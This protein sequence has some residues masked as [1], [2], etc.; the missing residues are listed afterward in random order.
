[1]DGRLKAAFDSVSTEATYRWHTRRLLAQLPP[2]YV[3]IQTVLG[4][5]ADVRL[6]AWEEMFL[7]VKLMSWIRDLEVP[8][9]EG[10]MGPLVLDERLLFDSQT[11]SLER[12]RPPATFRWFLGLGLLWGI[13]LTLLTLGRGDVA[14][15]RRLGVCVL[16]GGWAVLAGFSGTLILAAWLFTDHFFWY[17]NYNLFQVNPLGLVMALGFAWLVFTARMPKWTGRLAALLAALS[18]IG[19]LIQLLPGLGQRNA[20]FLALAL[21]VNLAVAWAAH[22]W[23]TKMNPDV[24]DSG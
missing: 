16:A 9:D 15:I 19:F 6:S 1:L 23:R 17:R 5:R 13:L 24:P 22:W 20:E 14:G 18:I 7:P 4:P 11:R 2:Y 3:G 12:A 21:P 8:D 10:V